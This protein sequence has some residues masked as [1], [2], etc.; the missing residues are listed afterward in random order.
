MS[1][2]DGEIPLKALA[3]IHIRVAKEN[4]RIVAGPVRFDPY[5]LIPDLRVTNVASGEERIFTQRR[6]ALG[7]DTVL[8][9]GKFYE[10]PNLAIY[11]YCE[12]VQGNTVTWCMVESYQL[13]QLIQAQFTQDVTYARHYVEV[14]DRDTLLRLRR[15][16]DRLK[17]HDLTAK[18]IARGRITRR[19]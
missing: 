9:Q 2:D 18:E 17:L 10:N 19:I 13:G 14:T 12:G 4:A 6:L 7:F 3:H 5:L 16:L 15:R 1:P 8:E 11:Y